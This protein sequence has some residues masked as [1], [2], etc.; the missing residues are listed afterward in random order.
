MKF[1]VV[2]LI[3]LAAWVPL[4]ASQFSCHCQ[5][6]NDG[7]A[8]IAAIRLCDAV[9]GTLCYNSAGNYNVCKTSSQWTEQQCRDT[10]KG[11][12]QPNERFRAVCTAY[13]GAG[14]PA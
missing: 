8:V 11:I 2:S 3:S 7:N 4:A 1:N 13:N 5:I 10:F 12:N 9:G 6:I 14:C